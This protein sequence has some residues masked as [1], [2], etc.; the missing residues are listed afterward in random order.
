[1]RTD[2]HKLIL[3]EDQKEKFFALIHAYQREKLFF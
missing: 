3:N 1:M 2:K